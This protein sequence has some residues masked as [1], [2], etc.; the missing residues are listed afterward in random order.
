MQTKKG[1][2]TTSAHSSNGDT[3]D[4]VNKKGLLPRDNV[5]VVEGAKVYAPNATLS[6][7]RS[8]GKTFVTSASDLLRASTYSASGTQGYVAGVRDGPEA[9]LLKE[10]RA[11]RAK[12]KKRSE[13]EL[14]AL[15]K[16][17]K[18]KSVGGEY[19]AAAAAVRKKLEEGKAEAK[20]E[21]E[22]AKDKGLKRK[23]LQGRKGPP[24]ASSG[25]SDDGSDSEQEEGEDDHKSKK[26]RPFSVAAVR[27][28][29]FD[30]T[31]HREPDDDAAKKQ[32]VRHDSLAIRPG[33]LAD[34]ASP[35][36]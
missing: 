6:N 16:D 20:A 22:R 2:S 12:D 17:D 30:P 23:K 34:F 32:K 35:L 10:E 4:P 28:I 18:G 8:S 1:K 24:S 33:A 21:K 5:R 25:S 31:N 7:G 15:I 29:G 11:K 14:K 27:L 3:Y 26:K 9:N 19:V 13:K 36:A